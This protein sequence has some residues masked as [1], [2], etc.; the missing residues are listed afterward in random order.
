MGPVPTGRT[1]Q[2]PYEIVFESPDGADLPLDVADGSIDL[3]NLI[4][5]S[6]K[7]TQTTELYD[8]V[9][10]ASDVRTDVGQLLHSV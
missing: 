1:D 9:Q 4:N 5:E 3:I 7:V 10:P 6:A 8:E 2:Q